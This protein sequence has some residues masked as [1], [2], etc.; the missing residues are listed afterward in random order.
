MKL[1]CYSNVGNIPNCH[2]YDEGG[3]TVEAA[4][5]K[6][7][8]YNTRWFATENGKQY[9]DD[10]AAEQTPSFFKYRH[11]LLKI[12]DEPTPR[13]KCQAIPETFESYKTWDELS[14]TLDFFT[15]QITTE[16][17]ANQWYFACK[18]DYYAIVSTT[19]PLNGFSLE[20]KWDKTTGC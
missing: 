4:N 20:K 8:H 1:R 12:P 9:Y 3:A 7:C 10:K 16:G 2:E 18:K 13:T 11:F 15:K 14:E 5:C 17:I 6:K 19:T